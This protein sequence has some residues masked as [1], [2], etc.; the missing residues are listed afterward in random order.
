MPGRVVLELEVEELL[1]LGERDDLVE[2]PRASLRESPSMTALMI[3][4]SRAVRSGLKPTP[5]SM[6]GDSR[7][8]TSMLPLSGS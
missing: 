7:P 2:A 8:S 6:N 3:T 5:S 4:L 1:E